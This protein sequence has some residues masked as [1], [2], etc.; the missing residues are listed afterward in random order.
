MA[1]FGLYADANN[2]EKLSFKQTPLASLI[3]CKG[4]FGICKG[5]NGIT[6]FRHC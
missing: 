1:D 6:L 4:R 3:G 2:G 5:R